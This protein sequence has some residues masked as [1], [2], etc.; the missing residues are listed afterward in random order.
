VSNASTS[1]TTTPGTTA[2]AV[3]T[4]AWTDDFD[5]EAGSAPDASRW[6]FNLGG[7]GWGNNELQTYTDQ[8]ATLD[9]DSHLAIEATIDGSTYLSSSVVTTHALDYGTL[10]A[11]IKLPTG[12]GLLP[13]FWLVGA[14]V[15]SVG[16]PQAGEIDVVETPNSTWTSH[17]NIHGPSVADPSTPVVATSEVDHSVAL[18]DDWHTYSVTRKPGWV[19]IYLDDLLVASL[20]PTTVPTGMTWVFDGPFRPILSLAIGGNWPGAPDA[21]TPAVSTMLVDWVRFEPAG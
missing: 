6:T 12:Q 2:A 10:S 1:D 15:G 19:L 18:G 8:N 14:D 7:G 11:R 21:T 16:W 4:G 17:H 13:A 5:G 3:D 9:G 20:T